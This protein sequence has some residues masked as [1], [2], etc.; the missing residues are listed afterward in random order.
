MT[1]ATPKL[2][3]L[4]RSLAVAGAFAALAVTTGSFAAAPSEERPSVKVRYDDLN[5]T[6]TAGVNALYRR[7]S[8]AASQ[9]CPDIYSRDLTVSAAGR[10]CRASAIAEA[11]QTVNN[12]QLALVHAAHTSRG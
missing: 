10:R 9:V 1:T 12:P 2:A 3:T 8:H 11:V 5:L 4:R 7:I 6:T